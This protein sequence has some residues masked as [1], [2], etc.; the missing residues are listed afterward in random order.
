[1]DCK[2]IANPAQIMIIISDVSEIMANAAI[3]ISPKCCTKIRLNVNTTMPAE[4]SDSPSDE[5]L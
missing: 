3:P 5:P 1:M 2:V 4:I